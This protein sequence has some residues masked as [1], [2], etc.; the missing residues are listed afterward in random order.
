MVFSYNIIDLEGKK[1]FDDEIF[2]FDSQ[3]LNNS[4]GD[5]IKLWNSSR[6]QVEYL[7]NEKYLSYLL[8]HYT[9]N[10][11]F[12]SGRLNLSNFFLRKNRPF[13][14]L[15]YFSIFDVTDIIAPNNF[16]RV[17]DVTTRFTY[18]S[19]LRDSFFESQDFKHSL[20]FEF[21]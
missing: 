8:N 7:V 2:L 17:T 21:I 14:Q 6:S 9:V 19:A 16:T 18:N 3:S 20:T 1:F 12:Y 4:V 11:Y 10:A 5:F 13:F 15:S